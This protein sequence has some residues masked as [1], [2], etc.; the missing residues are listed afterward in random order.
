MNKNAGVVRCFLWLVIA[1]LV[2]MNAMLLS[3]LPT[4]FKTLF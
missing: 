3:D 2:A 4:F 1:G